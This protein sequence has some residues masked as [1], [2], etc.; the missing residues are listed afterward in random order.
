MDIPE[1]LL[2]DVVGL[3][4]DDNQ[5]MPVVKGTL[6]FDDNGWCYTFRI[7]DPDVKPNI[8]YIASAGT[9][10]GAFYETADAAVAS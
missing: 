4:L 3:V 1:S 5:M 6:K 7:D 9:V 10:R 2:S 8:T